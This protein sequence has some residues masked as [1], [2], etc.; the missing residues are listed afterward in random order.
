[1]SDFVDS[2]GNYGDGYNAGRAAEA[3]RIRR[4]EVEPLVSLLK[5]AAAVLPDCSCGKQSALKRHC[6][7]AVAACAARYE[8]KP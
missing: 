6:E 3:A 7:A 5:E 1:M 4:E 2:S 8:G